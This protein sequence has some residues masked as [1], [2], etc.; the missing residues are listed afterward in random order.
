MMKEGDPAIKGKS[1]LN[2]YLRQTPGHLLHAGHYHRTIMVRAFPQAVVTGF[3]SSLSTADVDPD[4]AVRVAVRLVPARVRWDWRMRWKLR[5]LEASIR[6][7]ESQP[8]EMAR[9]EEV[10]ALEALNYLRRASAYSGV[11]I[12]DLWLAVTVTAT[13]E[14]RLTEAAAEMQR[15]LADMEMEGRIPFYEQKDAFLLSGWLPAAHP[16]GRFLKEYQGRLVDRDAASSFWPFTS[17]SLSDGNGVY[18]GHRAEDGSS[19]YLDLTEGP[20]N[21]NF[22]VVGSSGE[23][24]ST[25]IKSLALSLLLEGYRVFVFDVDGE[26]RPLCQAAGGVWI[27]HTLASGRYSDPAVIPQPIGSVEEDA[28]RLDQA[29]AAMARVISLLAGGMDPD[30][31]NAADR[32][33]LQ[34][35]EEAGVCMEEPATWNKPHGGIRRW[36]ALL[37]QDTSTGAV[38]L[39]EKLWRYFEGSLRRFFGEADDLAGISTARF[40]VFHVAQSVNNEVDAHAGAVKMAMALDSVWNEVRRERVRGKGY[41]AVF[42]DEGQRML[43]HPLASDFV[44]MLATAIRK[45]N[46]LLVLATNKPQVL[47]PETGGSPGGSGLWENSEFKVFFWMEASAAKAMGEHAELPETVIPHVMSLHGT[48]CYVLRTGRGFDTLRLRLAPEEERLFRTRGLHGS[49]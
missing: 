31:A 29:A 34:L 23:G 5:R 13:S 46:G 3:L 21:K 18:V 45:Y 15:I 28:A 2:W 11:E 8:G 40:V 4:V 20:G 37:G 36:Y 32:A 27:D 33:F 24:K 41:T 47:W 25:F 43:A 42:C 17:G 22:L 16:P 48:Y 10:K 7:A 12:Y 1:T 39:R 19:V 6:W 14:K 9:P 38:T 44:N 49:G 30:E 26:Y 35:W